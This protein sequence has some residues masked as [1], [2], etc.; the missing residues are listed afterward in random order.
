MRLKK[1]QIHKLSEQI[2]R[3]LKAKNLITLRKKEGEVLERIIKVIHDDLEAEAKL[4]EDARK[5][6]DAYR[7][8]IQSGSV[9]ENRLFQMIKKQLAKDRKLTI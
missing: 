2:L 7:D 1:E 9:D 6:M 3:A 4:D 8:Q 5:M